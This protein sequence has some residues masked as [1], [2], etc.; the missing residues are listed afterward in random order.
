MYFIIDFDYKCTFNKPVKSIFAFHHFTLYVIM[1]YMYFTRTDI[2]RDREKDS[3]L[4]TNS[5]LYGSI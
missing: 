3:I 2:Q 4:N 5:V 1:W